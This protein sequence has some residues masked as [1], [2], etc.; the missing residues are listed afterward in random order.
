[1]TALQK[2]QESFYLAN[3]TTVVTENYCGK[4]A[5]ASGLVSYAMKSANDFGSA[6]RV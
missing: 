1:M 2:Y 3:R 4:L 6:D 5:V